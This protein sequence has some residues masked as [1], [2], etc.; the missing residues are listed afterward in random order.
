VYL[1]FLQ[2]YASKCTHCD[3]LLF[4]CKDHSL[5]TYTYSIPPNWLYTLA[6]CDKNISAL[7]IAIRILPHWSNT[8][9]FYF[10]LSIIHLNDIWWFWQPTTCS[11]WKSGKK[12][13]TR[14][15]AISK[16]CQ[17]SC[18]TKMPWMKALLHYDWLCTKWKGCYDY[19][20]STT[21]YTVVH[22]SCLKGMDLKANGEGTYTWNK[23]YCEL[24]TREFVLW[25]YSNNW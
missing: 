4:W 19:C 5:L 12:R 24:F 7:C 1:F 2:N 18:A 25:Q 15:S 16:C 10:A 9:A 11:F 21:F 22:L 14:S 17:E 13:D 6:N 3:L 20:F 8:F 23:S